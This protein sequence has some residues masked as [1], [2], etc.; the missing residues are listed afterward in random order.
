MVYRPTRHM[1]GHFV[2]GRVG[3]LV[4]WPSRPKVGQGAVHL[5]INGLRGQYGRFR[6]RANV[7]GD[8][9]RICQAQDQFLS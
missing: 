4:H 3:R 1:I 5:L 8:V 9:T 2:T 7:T 6:L